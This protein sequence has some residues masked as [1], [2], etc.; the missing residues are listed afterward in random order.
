MSEQ[1]HVNLGKPDLQIGGVKL[2]GHGRQ[3]PLAQD[4]WGWKLASSSRA[5]RLREL[6]CFNGRPH[7]ASGGVGE[8]PR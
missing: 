5:M 3:F 8:T 4:Y 2:W 7:C 1:L 6:N